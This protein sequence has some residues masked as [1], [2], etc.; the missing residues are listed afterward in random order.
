MSKSLDKAGLPDSPEDNDAIMR[1]LLDVG[2][3]ITPENRGR[4]RSEVAAP[5]GT[6]V[7]QST[8]AVLDDGT[9]YLS[10]IQVLP[11]K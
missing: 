1:H 5:N 8:W 2:Q 3:N 6:L 10:T 4:F 7:I 9:V 11:P